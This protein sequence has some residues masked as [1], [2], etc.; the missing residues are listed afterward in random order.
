MKKLRICM[1]CDSLDL[2]GAE[3]HVVTLAVRLAEMGHEVTVVSGGGRLVHTLLGV[4]HIVLPRFRKRALPRLFFS[5]SRIF[6][7][8]KYDVIHAHTR[9]SAFLCRLLAKK[10]LVVTAHWVFDASFP[11][12]QLT[13]WG[14]ETL[15]VSPDIS[16]YLT[17]IYGCKK[18][19]ITVTVN[20][21]DT[22]RFFPQKQKTVMR[23]IVCCTRM[24]RDRADA[25]FALLEA[26]EALPTKDISLTLIGDGDRFEE[27]KHRHE[28]LKARNPSL[29]VRLT[30]G[31]ADVAPYLTDADIF[32][33]VSRAALEAMAA[34]CATILAGNEGYLS[35]FSPH[36]AEEAEKSNFCCRGAEETTPKRLARDLLRL[37]RVSRE[38][39]LFMGEENRRYV[40]SRYGVDRMAKDALAVYEK[41][42]KRQCVLCGYYGFHNVG[43]TLLARALTEHL[44]K[45]GYAHVLLLSKKLL[46]LRAF[47]ALLHG[48][49]LILGGGNLLQDATSRR[50]LQFYLFCTSLA[51]RV[52]IYGG[53]GP[54]SFTGEARVKKLLTRAEYVHA[55]T[56]GDLVYAKRL[57]ASR[58]RLSA[59]TVLAL[60]FPKK[61]KGEDILL[62]FHSPSVRDEPAIIAFT[63]SLCRTFGC[64]HLCIF[65]MHPD[66]KSF[67]KRLA[68][69]CRIEHEMG[70]C[71]AFLSRLAKCRAVFASRLHAGVCALGTEIPFFLW[72][73]DQKCCFF[74]EDLKSTVKDADFCALFSYNDRITELPKADGIKKAKDHMRN[75]I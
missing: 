10:R 43:D 31:V 71:D 55:R 75:R 62:A 51:R 49:N 8:G 35:I 56:T 44:K 38:E 64:E 30:G 26:I 50:S 72:K 7:K 36:N 66:D 69:L 73:G 67:A 21:I 19:H 14:N 24:D 65:S 42:C 27:L 40:C 74:I 68:L 34:G 37:I 39:L 28:K 54:L 57:G 17:D 12:K 47:F 48:Y 5:L 20:G 45:E 58:V 70:D 2:G 25:A 13:A 59:D 33:G 16:D 46:S 53:L 22:E 29:D 3:T 32:V 15:A 4:K 63:L 41:I 60:P 9:L 23:R 52:E 1:V 18:E 61:E 11:K 6:R